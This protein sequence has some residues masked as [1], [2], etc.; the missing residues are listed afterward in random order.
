MQ[1]ENKTLET[2]SSGLSTLSIQSEK[3]EKSNQS[4]EKTNQS[5]KSNQSNE[6]TN[7]S[8]EKTIKLFTAISDTVESI[9]QAIDNPM[10][11]KKH[12]DIVLPTML[13]HKVLSSHLLNTENK[14]K[15]VDLFRKYFIDNTVHFETEL[16]VNSLKNT[17]ID[18]KDIGLNTQKT[19]LNFKQIYSILNQEHQSVLK[20]HLLYLNHLLNKTQKS[21]AI[22]KQFLEEKDANKP[23][24]IDTSSKEGQLANDLFKFINEDD[25]QTMDPKKLSEMFMGRGMDKYGEIKPSAF[26]MMLGG[27][28]ASMEKQEETKK[29]TDKL[30]GLSK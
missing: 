18:A 6:K 4:N 5:D 9:K 25:G 26:L 12:Q 1:G 7:Q 28:A 17:S 27:I 13:F 3:P 10:L 22:Y 11:K 23:I 21:N 20:E 24:E 30:L 16:N 8:N 14:H 15:F 2:V 29:K 19:F